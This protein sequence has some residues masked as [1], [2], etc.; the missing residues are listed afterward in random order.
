MKKLGKRI[1]LARVGRDLTQAKLAQKIH[2]KQ[3]T[4]SLY[5]R[6]LSVPPLDNLLKLAKALKKSAAYFLES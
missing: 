2:A 5:E 6:G 1:K 3:K 4:I